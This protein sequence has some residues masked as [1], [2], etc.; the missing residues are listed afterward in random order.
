MS[1]YKRGGTWWYKFNW[2]GTPI[3]ESTKQGNKRV[4]ETIEAA[5]KT[6]LAKGE[7]GI[8]DRAPVP[9]LRDFVESEFKNY[10]ET[11][12][13]EKK[14]TLAYYRVN[15]RYLTEHAPLASAQLDVISADLVSAFIEKRR[16]AGYEVSSTNRTLQ[17][18][19]RMLKLAEE[20]GKV[21]KAA[22]I[23]MQPGEKRRE[24]VLSLEEET[25]YMTAASDI[26]DSILGAY[27]R[28]VEG[29]RATQRGQKPV[30]PEDPYLLRDA[31]TV[32]LDCGLRPEE[33]HRLRWDEVRDGALWIPFGKSQN[34]R[35]VIPLESRTAAM[36][37]MRKTVAS[38]PWVFSAPTKSGHI[39]QSSLKKQHANACKLAKIEPLPPYT[40]RHTRLTRWA[41]YLS[42]F[43]LAY[44]AGHSDFSTTKRYVH[45]NVDALRATMERA[46]SVQSGHNSGHSAERTECAE[47]PRQ[48]LIV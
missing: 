2:N 44:L 43:D 20:W 45:P 4:A 1:V 14:A 47:S 40:F 5:R 39:E 13:V 9:T 29:I 36:L 8:K 15:I 19:R 38:G 7:V 35:R 12:F 18:L 21:S 46:R 26:G 23:T 16:A 24:R 37:D 33:L 30:K 6:E 3:R 28:A 31:A 32:L 22:R 10:V 34:A 41:A 11:R 48:S 27:E 25:R 42:P 17:V